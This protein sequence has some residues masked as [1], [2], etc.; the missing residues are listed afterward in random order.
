MAY[1][2]FSTGSGGSARGKSELLWQWRSLL[3]GDLG[4]GSWAITSAPCGTR[5][6]RSGETSVSRRDGRDCGVGSRNSHGG[7]SNRGSRGL[8]GSPCSTGGGT[9]S[10]SL[11]VGLGS[12]R[13]GGS[14]S[15]GGSSETSSSGTGRDIGI[16][17]S[18][19]T[20]V[21]AVNEGSTS[22]LLT[23]TFPPRP[24]FQE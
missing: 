16:R 15:S 13:R 8:V 6:G 10:R 7:S 11:A 9:S 1:L 24:C 19:N 14:T 4:G 23:L 12:S 22:R 18:D 21:P 5:R 20:R 17:V 3:G 2:G